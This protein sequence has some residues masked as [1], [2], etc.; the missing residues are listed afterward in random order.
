[1]SP[2]AITFNSETVLQAS[3]DV[4]RQ[5]GWD[6]LTARS[7]AGRLGASVA[8]VYSAFGS[9]ENLLRAALVNMRDLLWNYTSRSYSELPFLNIGA[10]IVSFAR[11]EPYFFQALFQKRHGFQDV[12][13]D[14]NTT[15][16]SWMKNDAQL[17]LLS[18]AA[19]ERLYDSIGFFT[20]GLAAAVAAGRV[21]DVSDNNIIRLLKNMGN[22]LMYA[23]ISGVSDS[24]SPESE[25]EWS[26]LLKEKKISL[27][28]SEKAKGFRNIKK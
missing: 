9:M 17:G 23:E 4:V 7:V 22:S 14:V 25:K 11:D 20:M 15:I 19:R 10:G 13:E 2:K 1:M 3:L 8:P 28:D 16:L 5:Q 21:A 6:A 18:D 27:P 24:D 12:A 26:R